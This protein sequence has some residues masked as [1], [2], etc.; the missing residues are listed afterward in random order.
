MPNLIFIGTSEGLY[1][2]DDNLQT[3][4]NLLNNPGR[5][6]DIAFHP[7]NPNIIYLYDD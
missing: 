4:T 3:W 7:T 2:S 6:T 5:I 1:R